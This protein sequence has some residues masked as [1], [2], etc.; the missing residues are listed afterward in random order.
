VKTQTRYEVAAVAFEETLESLDLPEG[1]VEDK[2]TQRELGRKAAMLAT[3]DLQWSEHVGPLVGWRDVADLLKSVRTRQGVHDLARRGRLL[4]LP[5]KD[6]QLVYPLFQF[7]D[8]KPLPEMP[9]IIEAFGK[10]RISPWTLASWMVT[11]QRPLE[12]ASPVEWLKRGRSSETVLEAASRRA[13]AL[14]R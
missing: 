8:G 13:A 2:E 14:E 12:G 6:G 4:A 1:S 3:A 9:R 5:T 10:A 7:R 11:P